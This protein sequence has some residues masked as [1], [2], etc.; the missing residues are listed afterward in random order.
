LALVSSLR[1][2]SAEEIHSLSCSTEV[3]PIILEFTKLL[4]FTNARANCVTDIHNLSASFIY[5][6]V[7]ARVLSLKF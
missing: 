6:A 4:S 5:S 3:A 2:I 1:I 7:A